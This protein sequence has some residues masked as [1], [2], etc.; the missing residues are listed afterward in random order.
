MGSCIAYFLLS[1]DRCIACLYSMHGYLFSI[2][3]RQT[4]LI[5]CNMNARLYPMKLAVLSYSKLLSIV[6]I[7]YFFLFSSLSLR[8][9]KSCFSNEIL[10]QNYND[11]NIAYSNP[12]GWSKSTTHQRLCRNSLVQIKDITDK[13]SLYQLSI[14]T[15]SY[16]YLLKL[17]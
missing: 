1:F 15:S 13:L 17:F 8:V 2:W 10:I 12:Y 14:Y 9:Y 5:S 6:F 16:S 4:F 7:T 11:N 3:Y